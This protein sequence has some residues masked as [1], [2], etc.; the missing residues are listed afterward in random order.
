MRHSFP[1]MLILLAACGG[2]LPQGGDLPTLAALPT[3][4]AVTLAP[5]FTGASPA[6]EVAALELPTVAC[7][8]EDCTTILLP[9]PL[10]SA[11]PEATATVTLMP[12]ATITD[13]P[14]PIATVTRIASATAYT[15]TY[16]DELGQLAAQATILPPGFT[17]GGTIVAGRDSFWIPAVTLTAAAGRT[18]NP[19]AQTDC[20]A[21]PTGGFL[22]AISQN[23]AI[24]AE[25]GCIVGTPYSTGS[26][27]QPFERGLMVWVQNV[28]AA[29]G[30]IYVGQP[31]NTA[32]I[33]TDTWQAGIDPESGGETP[34]SGLIEPV[35]GFGKIWRQAG[36]IRNAIGW[37]TAPEQ[38]IS[39][40]VLNF[41]RGRMIALAER[42]EILIVGNSGVW[43]TVAGGA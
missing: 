20:S 12:S 30:M 2:Q 6:P 11:T 16:I 15:T 3:A 41:E 10:P 32:L 26:A 34:P 37:A 8:D 22:T 7:V 17:V 23:P 28:G 27:Y 9:T 40:T 18:G 29:G 43:F 13:T 24:V 1:L 35:R 14:S 25:I 38:G 36:G 21:N 31:N 5:P 33:V 4:F 42:G 19:L 39:A